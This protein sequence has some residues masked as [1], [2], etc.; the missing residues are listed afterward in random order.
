MSTAVEPSK[1]EELATEIKRLSKLIENNETGMHRYIS[2]LIQDTNAQYSEYYVRNNL[3]EMQELLQE[4]RRLAQSITSKLNDK[5]IVLNNAANIYRAE[6]E[7]S[8]KLAQNLIT[9]IFTAKKTV[10]SKSYT[11][12]NSVV[13][14]SSNTISQKGYTPNITRRQT[15]PFGPENTIDFYPVIL[16][17]G[18]EEGY[19]VSDEEKVY[20][21]IVE[22]NALN[23]DGDAVPIIKISITGGEL[24]DRD[25]NV[26]NG[27]CTLSKKTINK[28]LKDTDN[29]GVSKKLPNLISKINNIDWLGNLT[30]SNENKKYRMSSREILIR[31]NDTY[32]NIDDK[33]AIS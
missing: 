2:N 26:I 21:A 4:I 10:V 3:S 28:W 17:T 27:G 7:K 12:K 8:K 14:E 30:T 11:L 31:N 20:E 33:F 1:I 25:G 15:I 24:C 23:Y 32:F 18:T 5:V 22:M 29:L 16:R 19:D 13:S 6:E 9:K